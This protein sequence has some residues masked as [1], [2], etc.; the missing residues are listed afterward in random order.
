MRTSIGARAALAAMV[1][2]AG[3]LFG[4]AAAQAQDVT[5]LAAASLKNA[6]DDVGALF[7]QKTGKGV[8]ASYA[9]S[10]ALAKQIE[11]GA[12][13][14]LFFSADL[15][16]MDYL[17]KRNLIRPETRTN[18][19][20][21]RLVLIAPAGSTVQVELKP[22]VD[23]AGLV[24][25]ARIATGDPDSVPVG[26]YAK[27]AFQKFGV[28]DAVD[29]KL[30]RTDNVRAA[31][32]LVSRGE[33]PLGIVYATD[34]A[35]DKGVRVVATFPADSHPPVLYPGALVAPGA[36]PAAR[37]YLAFLRSAEALGVFR[38]YGFEP[39]ADAS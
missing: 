33:A 25:D 22:G 3:L 37:D 18:L 20:G 4:A 34:A 30:A 10:S 35:V 2:G 14:D 15:D 8:T 19:L 31:L 23:L 13:A 29:R 16:W 39:L 36:N 27:A 24:G 11:Q 12:P 38:K 1:V 17:E 9:A 7:K 32:A 21:N 5:V 26:R 6:L 28:W